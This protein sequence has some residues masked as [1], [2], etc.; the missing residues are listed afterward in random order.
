MSAELV[1]GTTSVH[2]A[3]S[4]SVFWSARND[5]VID[6]PPEDVWA[7]IN[8][9][10]IEAVHSWN[11]T[12]VKVDR[13][14]GENGQENELVLVT[15]DTD[16]DPFYMLT[17]RSVPNRQRVLRID[18]VDRSYCGYVDHSLYP[19]EDGRTHLVYN[20]YLEFRRVPAGELEER[21][22]AAAAAASME[23]LNHGWGL[24]KQVVEERVPA[25]A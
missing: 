23:Y 6:R 13:L 2:D 3:L 22:S 20:G 25:P 5:I 17:I 11:P 9:Q 21:T 8:D 18:S 10:D 16:Q 1:T 12:V 7:V 19:L 15:K 14:A 24:L 4:A